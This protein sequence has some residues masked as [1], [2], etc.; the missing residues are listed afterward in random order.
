MQIGAVGGAS[1]FSPPVRSVEQ[2]PAASQGTE[3]VGPETSASASQ[4]SAAAPGAKADGVATA[5]VASAAPVQRDP[6]VGNL[7][8]VTA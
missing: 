3:K 7:L 5:S 8:N 1:N 4:R 6:L 2:S